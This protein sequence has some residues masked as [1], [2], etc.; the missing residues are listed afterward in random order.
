[1]QLCNSISL[2]I[3]VIVFFGTFMVLFILSSALIQRKVNFT[4]TQRQR[5]IN[6][7]QKMSAQYMSGFDQNGKIVTQHKLYIQ[8]ILIKYTTPCVDVTG[9]LDGHWSW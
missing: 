2:A 4:N 3:T 6:H 7:I 5:T 9:I 8:H 1:M